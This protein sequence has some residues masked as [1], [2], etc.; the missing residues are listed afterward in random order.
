MSPFARLLTLVAVALF[1]ASAAPQP[2]AS[3][4]FLW[5]EDVHGARALAW[6]K[7]ENAKTLTVLQRDPHFAGFYAQALAAGESQNRVPAPDLIGGRVYNFWQDAHH[8]RGIWRTTTIADY[9][10]P[11]PAWKTVLDLDALAA[12]EGEN[13]V[14]QGA[15]CDSPSRQRCL[16]SFSDGGEDAA[17]IR[18]FDLRTARFVPGGFDFP[19][20]KQSVAWAG[21]NSVLVARP[22]RPADVTASGYAYIVKTLERG[23]PLRNAVEVMRGQPSDVDTS[24]EELHDAQGHRILAI[25]RNVSFFQ[26]KIWLVTPRGLRILDV[27]LKSTLRALV[28]GRL[29]ISLAQLW[30]AGSRT[31]PAGDL[32]SLDLAAAMADPQHLKPAVVYAPGPRDSLDGVGASRDRLIVTSYHNVRGRATVYAPAANGGWA[33]RALAVPDYASIGLY[34]ADDSSSTAYVGITRFLAPTTVLA[35]DTDTGASHV[36]KARPAL[37]DGSHDVV[38]QDEAISKDGT[39]IPYFIVRPKQLRYDGGNPTLLNAYGGFGVSETPFYSAT[40][41]RLWLARGGVFVLANIRGGSEFGPAWH[42]AGLKTHRQRIYDDFT[43]VA[44]DLV[45]RK[46]TRPRRLGIMGGSNG[47]LLM[48]VEFTQHPELFGAVDIEV[49]LLD[50]LRYEKIDAGASWVDEYGSVTNPR[51]RAFLAS[52]SPYNN[53]HAGV[54]YPEPLIWTTTKDD[55]VGPQHAR[56][57]AAKLAALHVPYFFYEVTE[58]GH[59]SGANARERAFTSALEYTYLTRRLMQ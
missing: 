3:D 6:V 20:A 23:E 32:V 45:A 57:F 7:A 22:W 41:G 46:I 36:A 17:T 51:E 29:V 12:A 55:R 14:W 30:P 18:E 44:R 50:M 49:P 27:P 58:G 4:P 1:A 15:D 56:K 10:K 47:G 13:W 54:H 9:A 11:A 5:L 19:R 28:A 21:E 16:I 35:L 25:V 53:L 38:E 26:N 42:E 8:V 52:I 40:L 48:G 39:R 37:F 24:P 2:G 33:P 34:A 59:G 43:A 31:F